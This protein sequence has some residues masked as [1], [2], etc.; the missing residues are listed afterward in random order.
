MRKYVLLAERMGA[1]EAEACRL[2]GFSLSISRE[3]SASETKEFSASEGYSIRVLKGKRL[4]FAYFAKGG[5][6]KGAIRTALAL[7]KFSNLTDFSFPEKK[8]F[9]KLE[10]FDKNVA[11]LGEEK[12]AGMLAELA[13]PIEKPVKVAKAGL[14][15]GVGEIELENSSGL[16]ASRSST[17]ISCFAHCTCKKSSGSS[18]RDSRFLDFRPEEVGKEASERAVET[19]SAKP[20][21]TGRFPAVLEAEALSS[22]FY[23]LLL[24]SFHGERAYRKISQLHDK[25]G[26][27]IAS[28]GLSL[29]DNPLLNGPGSSHFDGE[30]IGCKEKKLIEKGVA[31]NFLFDLKTASLAG[32]SLNPSPGNCRRGSNMSEPGIGSSNMV[33]GNGKSRDILRE[34]T[35]GLLICSVFGEHTANDLTGEFSVSV[36]RGFV[37]RDGERGKP[38]RGNVIS[39][40][41][42]EL[43]RKI[44][45]IESKQERSGSFISP[46]IAFGEIH[47][48][49]G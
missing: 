38:I 37:I 49:G 41:V 30:G 45:A 24:P 36:E 46:R 32:D 39:G 26:Q 7:S 4:G 6:A 31:S 2:F 3:G 13:G 23:S 48:V 19:S 8:R 14:D 47:V 40:N 33:V 21:K 35:N 5:D 16:S 28:G 29:A 44:T 12:A 15:S 27:G 43:I 34:C 18:F 9:P 17:H 25:L 20:V 1:D 11:G 42:F 10:T 22:L